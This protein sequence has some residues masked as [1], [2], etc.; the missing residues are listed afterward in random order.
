MKVNHC[1]SKEVIQFLKL[2]K[3]I[4]KY[5]KVGFKNQ[6]EVYS[7]ILFVLKSLNSNLEFYKEII[8]VIK[9]I[10]HFENLVKSKYYYDKS[11]KRNLK[12][13]KKINALYPKNKI[14][15]FYDKNTIS[16][17]GKFN[18][19]NMENRLKYSLNRQMI[20]TNYKWNEVLG[21]DTET[22]KGRVMLICR[23]DVNNQSK[24]N[25]LIKQKG[26]AYTFKEV[27]EFLTYHINTPN[28]YRFFYNIDFDVQAIFKLYRKDKYNKLSQK[29][30]IDY[31]SKGMSIIYETEKHKYQL[32]WIRTKWFSIRVIGRKKRV[33]WFS[34]LLTFYKIGLGKAGKK[35]LNMPKD[36]IDGNK[37]NTDWNYWYKNKDKII[38]YCIRDCNITKDLGTLLIKEVE[39]NNLPL[40][41]YLV[42]PASLSKQ[43]FRYKNFIPNLKHTPIKITQIGYNCFFGGRF[44]IKKKGFIQNGFLYDIISQYP[45]FIKQL[46]DMFNGFWIEH[47]NLSE[48]PKKQCIGYF[49]CLVKIPMNERLPTLPTKYKGLVCFSNGTF[50][51]W[52]TWF[53]LDLM[54]KYIVQIKKAYIYEPNSNN[55]K[56]FSNGITELM[57]KKKQINKKENFLG[58]NTVKITMNGLYGCFI[59]KHE[60]YYLNKNNE[61]EKRFKAG[62]LFNPIYASQITAFGRWSVI[63]DIPKPKRK[64][65]V[66]IHTD[67]IITDIDCSKYLKIGNELGN[68][69]LES[70]GKTLIIATGQYQI[71]KIVKHRGIPKKYIK[72]WFKFCKKNKDKD[73]F[74][75]IIKHM[76]KARESL[77]RDKSTL[78]INIMSDMKRSVK[79]N[80]DIKQTWLKDIDNFKMLYNENVSCYPYYS[81]ENEFGLSLNPL[82]ISIKEKIPLKQVYYTLRES[83]Y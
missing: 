33:V 77:T 64:H 53:D 81:F 72:N 52:F 44:E 83:C 36:K 3:K 79:C 70:K 7:Y 12:R 75:F 9:N 43:F 62:K 45:F 17:N 15:S 42:S 66:A 32:N 82:G 65:I 27:I 68:W 54:R 5:L 13:Y 31:L 48:L 26:K 10:Q 41:K 49:K 16:M 24:K 63:K 80:S 2:R 69:N 29:T 4:R 37:L 34:D 18:P 25:Y 47:K 38:K 74:E 19:N 56:P 73:S 14:K 59:E 60:N 6:N 30:F 58:Y 40:P 1:S 50:W 28:V 57:N 11:C 67:S 55:F 8:E 39:K 23:N 76:K 61:T 20:T 46:P 78:P 51:K 21:Y 71:G 35:Y 22:Y